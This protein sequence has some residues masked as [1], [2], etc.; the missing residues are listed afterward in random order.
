M[1]IST[2]RIERPNRLVRERV[3]AFELKPLD[4]DTAF[5][6]ARMGTIVTAEASTRLETAHLELQLRWLLA[7]ARGE[8]FAHLIFRAG[9]EDSPS[10]WAAGGAGMRLVDVGVDSSFRFDRMPIPAAPADVRMRVAEPADVE[11]LADLAAEAFTLSRFSA[12]PF[13]SPE[14]V[15]EFHRTWTRNL[16][17][18]LARA[19]LVAEVD[20]TIAGFISCAVSDTDGRIPLIGVDARFRGRG[21]G[22]ALVAE[23]LRWFSDAGC[24]KA[25]VKT[26]AHN[27]AA[28]AL[29]HRAGFQ[30]SKSELTFSITL[31]AAPQI[32][33]EVLN[34]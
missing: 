8:G 28:L 12:D 27:Y 18:G 15:R 6:G 24:S 9:V 13:F 1:V 20:S 23:S 30:V 4:W 34:D 16:C 7:Q 5:F 31:D 33:T 11:T 14:Q 26:Q 22:Q 19:V 17:N 21:V 29:Y 2:V 25:H 32:P 3:Q 10:I